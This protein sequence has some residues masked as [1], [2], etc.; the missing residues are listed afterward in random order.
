[1]GLEPVTFKLLKETEMNA[2]QIEMIDFATNIKTG[3]Q[4]RRTNVEKLKYVFEM[5]L[6]EFDNVRH[7]FDDLR[8]AYQ[9]TITFHGLAEPVYYDDTVADMNTLRSDFIEQLFNSA[10]TQKPSSN[11]TKQEVESVIDYYMKLSQ[12]QFESEIWEA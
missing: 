7:Q 6:I 3:K 5:L 8:D 11:I 9:D 10:S 1:M 12:D 2:N 4:T